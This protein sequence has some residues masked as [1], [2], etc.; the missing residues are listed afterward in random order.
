MMSELSQTAAA[1]NGIS[2]EV[3]HELCAGNGSCAR[4]LPKVFEV[5]GEAG[6]ET[7]KARIRDGVDWGSVE[8]AQVILA[9]QACPWSA[10]ETGAD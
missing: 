7:G 1:A 10:I 5:T 2:I 4:S 6:T 3:D 9:A 8:P